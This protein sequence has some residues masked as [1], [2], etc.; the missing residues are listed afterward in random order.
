MFPA[1]L[2][3]RKKEPDIPRSYVVPWGTFGAWLWVL[4][5]EAGIAFT[6]ALFFYVV[7]EGTPKATYWAITAGGTAL[8]ILI[9]LLLY[10]PHAA[11]SSGQPTRDTGLKGV[12]PAE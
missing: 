12:E 5:C 6:I 1:L 2:V 3:L 7:P 11:V 9:G 4:L 10:K 8:S